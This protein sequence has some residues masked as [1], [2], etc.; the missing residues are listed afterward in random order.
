MITNDT[1]IPEEVPAASSGTFSQKLIGSHIGTNPHT[2]SQMNNGELEVEL[3]LGYPGG[4]NSGRGF[5]LGGPGTY[6]S[7]KMW[8][9]EDV[10]DVDGKKISFRKTF[11]S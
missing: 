8:K 2:G 10:V 6:R 5:G 1:W 4:T 3:V 9:K 11:E 7:G